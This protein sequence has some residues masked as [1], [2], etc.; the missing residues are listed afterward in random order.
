MS[1]GD[2][3]HSARNGFGS[4][5]PHNEWPGCVSV[6]SRAVDSGKPSVLYAF[7]VYAFA[8]AIAWLP[9]HALAGSSVATAVAQ[10]S[11]WRLTTAAH[12]IFPE[13]SPPA[14]PSTPGACRSQ[15]FKSF[16]DGRSRQRALAAPANGGLF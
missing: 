4:A 12:S 3:R 6:Y 15:F 11:P 13:K 10:I 8:L 14:W 2:A 9:G 5:T 1:L 7:A 16:A